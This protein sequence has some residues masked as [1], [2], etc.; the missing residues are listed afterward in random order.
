MTDQAMYHEGMRSLQDIRET[1]L[2]A[3]RLEQVT[4]RCA[5]TAEDRE[6]ISSRPMVRAPGVR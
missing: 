2:L 6:F 4:V 3:D 1:R 5:F